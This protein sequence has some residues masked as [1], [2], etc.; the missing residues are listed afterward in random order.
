MYINPYLYVGYM[1]LYVDKN[2]SL[3]VWK[4]IVLNS[5]HRVKSDY[6]WESGIDSAGDETVTYLAFKVMML[7]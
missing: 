4:D 3:Y 5:P 2:R 1:H 6:F 7:E